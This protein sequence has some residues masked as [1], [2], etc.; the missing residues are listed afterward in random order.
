MDE[1]EKGAVA[2]ELKALRLKLKELEGL[3][4]A[5]DALRALVSLGYITKEESALIFLGFHHSVPRSLQGP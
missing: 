4:Q 1:A 3:V 5:R 2:L